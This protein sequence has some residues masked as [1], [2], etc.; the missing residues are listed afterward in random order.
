M[1]VS[2]T[3]DG[4]QKRGNKW[5]YR[6]S[7][8]DPIT[9]KMKQV[10]ISGFRTKEEAKADRIRREAEFLEGKY[11]SKSLETIGSFFPKWFE[12]KVAKKPLKFSTIEQ[13]RQTLETYIYPKIGHLALQDLNFEILE[14][15][16]I[17]LLQNGKKN[18]QG[19]SHSSIRK[20]RLVLG[21]GFNYAVKCKKIAFNPMKEVD[22]PKGAEKKVKTFTAEEIKSILQKLSDHRLSAFFNLACF[23]G[24][25]RGE[26]LALRWSDFDPDLGNIS[27]SKTRGMAGGK[28]F[29]NAPKSKRGDRIIEISP[30][31]ISALLAHK[32]K[33]GLEKS[34][35]GNAWQ[36]SGYIFT[37]ADGNPIYPTTPS[38]IFEKTLKELGIPK[39]PFHSLR[40]THATELLRK[41]YPAYQVAKRLGDEVATVL[42]T[43]AHSDSEDDKGLALAF[44]ESIKSA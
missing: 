5:S 9:K 27:I 36:E 44:E 34:W 13:N 14:T 31:A 40:H 18:G 19:L 21:E 41:G 32:E 26:I 7:V 1:L 30:T 6:Y 4:F 2:E 16:L 3:K 15:F 22:I 8:K 23:T 25:R 10:R 33:Q 11:V 37:Q 42:N 43:Y 20:V 35:L 38:Q 29:E 28:I 24:A 39:R 17:S 12:N